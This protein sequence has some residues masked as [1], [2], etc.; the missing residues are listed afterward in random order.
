[1]SIDG[2]QV[3]YEWDEA[4]VNRA[5]QDAGERMW[6]KMDGVDW[7]KRRADELSPQTFPAWKA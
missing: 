7:G 2:R 6:S 5:L 3:L 4:A 1:V